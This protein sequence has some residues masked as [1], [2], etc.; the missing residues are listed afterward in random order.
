MALLARKPAWGLSRS[1]SRGVSAS[2]APLRLY[3]GSLIGVLL[4][5]AAAAAFADGPI[6]LPR[7]RRTVGEALTPR[8]QLLVIFFS[9]VSAPSGPSGPEAQCPASVA[10][11]FQLGSREE[12]SR[13]IPDARYVSD[14]LGVAVDDVTRLVAGKL[15]AEIGSEDAR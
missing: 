13:R 6:R 11:S 12:R 2:P 9:R 5:F 7:Y 4:Y 10:T 1:C 8:E 14:L 15:G 3:L